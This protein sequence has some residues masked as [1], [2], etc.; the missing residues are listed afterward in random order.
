MHV[1]H[2]AGCVAVERRRAAAHHLHPLGALQ[3][4]C[5]HGSLSVG[6][7]EGNAVL[8]H[9]DAPYAECG[10]RTESANADARILRRVLSVRERDAR[11]GEQQFVHASFPQR[12]ERVGARE[13]HRVGKVEGRARTL[14]RRGHR[15]GRERRARAVLRAAGRWREEQ[16]GGAQRGR[17]RRDALDPGRESAHVVVSSDRLRR[18]SRAIIRMANISTRAFATCSCHVGACTAFRTPPSPCCT[19]AATIHEEALIVPHA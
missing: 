15:D 9:A 16:G 18:A 2:S 10:A 6:K 1:D 8:Q 11:H 7:S 13:R 14:P 12:R 4:E 3:V 17:G 19:N 5:I